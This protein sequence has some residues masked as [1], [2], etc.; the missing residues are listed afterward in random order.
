V[1]IPEELKRVL[2]E[3]EDVLHERFPIIGD[4]LFIPFDN[5]ELD[6]VRREICLCLLFGLDQA[7]IT[8][9]NH[10]LERMLKNS[11]VAKYVSDN[12]DKGEIAG[13][14]LDSLENTFRPAIEKYGSANLYNNINS[15]LSHGLINEEESKVLHEFRD[16]YRNA[17]GHADVNKTFGSSTSTYSGFRLE[18]K[19]VKKDQIDTRPVAGIPIGQ[20]F[21]QAIMAKKE[22]LRYYTFIDGLARRLQ[23]RLFGK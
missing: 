1:C 6:S 17:Y 11:L 23:T 18:D 22:A 3:C 15:A 9:T 20:G 10:L 2:A 4:M 8:L 14:F 12:P 13:R 5:P 7:A 19:S 16:Y 21:I